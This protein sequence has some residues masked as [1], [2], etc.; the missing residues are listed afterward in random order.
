MGTSYFNPQS[1]GSATGGA[2][3]YRMKPLPVTS[4]LYGTGT[5]NTSSVPVWRSGAGDKSFDSS[6]STGITLYTTASSGNRTTTATIS[7]NTYLTGSNAMAYHLNSTDSCLYA[8]LTTATQLQLVKISDT[9]GT[10]TSIGSA[11]TPTTMAN[12]NNGTGSGALAIMTTDIA[13]GYLK[14][15]FNG[16]YHMLNKSTGAVV[17]QN[18]VISLGSYLARDVFYLTQDGST[19]VSV[20]Y[21]T[22]SFS[23]GRIAFP[24]TVSSSYGHLSS[25]GLAGAL[26]GNASWSTSAQCLNA[27]SFFTVDT[28]KICVSNSLTTT[29]SSVGARYYLI[30]DFDKF[31]KSVADLAAG[32]I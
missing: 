22:T 27:G 6:A 9:T 4:Q 23:D 16:F 11:I 8:L 19:G 2:L 21:G 32:V 17:S 12:W 29:T 30:S 14:I 31:V 3:L 20:D 26:T 5:T 7:Y 28:D 24:N 25:Y 15:T 18:N 13:T 1:S 10:V